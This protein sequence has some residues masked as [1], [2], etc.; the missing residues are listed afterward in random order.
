MIHNKKSKK[1]TK[2]KDI[3]KKISIK[4]INT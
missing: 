3:N 2:I 1:E 4:Q